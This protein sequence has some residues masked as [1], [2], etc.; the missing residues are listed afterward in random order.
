MFGISVTTCKSVKLTTG[1]KYAQY[2]DAIRVEYLEKG[3]R[4]A[5]MFVLAENN[6][7]LRV[8]DNA[9]AIIACESPGSQTGR[10]SGIAL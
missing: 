9:V 6:P 1:V 8:I 2:N 10:Y 5:R 7:W 4:N 3:K